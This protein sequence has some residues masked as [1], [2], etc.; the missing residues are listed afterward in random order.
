MIEPGKVGPVPHHAEG[1]AILVADRNRRNLE[2]L[3]G[4]LGAAGFEPRT[5]ASLDELDRALADAEVRL[6]LVDAASF[7]VRLVVQRLPRSVPLLI[8]CDR[9]HLACARRTL[10]EGAHGILEKPL[11]T[12]ELLAIVRSAAGGA[13]ESDPAAHRA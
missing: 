10:P 9:R 13:H 4:V 11:F 12:S 1:R 7:D 5:I 8:V 3:S 2:L 6:A